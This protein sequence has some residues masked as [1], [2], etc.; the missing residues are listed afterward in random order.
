M[1]I[2]Y[3]QRIEQIPGVREVSI[4]Q[5][6][7][8]VYKEP[9]NMFARMAVEPER[10]FTVYPEY[11][12][13][14]DQKKAFVQERS[15]CIIG[16]EISTKYGINIGDKMTLVGDIFPVTMEFVV[17]GIYDYAPEPES[18][19]FHLQYLFESLSARRRDFAGMFII[20]ADS[21]DSANRIGPVV[22]DMFRNSPAHYLCT[23]PLSNRALRRSGGRRVVILDN[24]RVLGDDPLHDCLFSLALQLR[25]DIN[26]RRYFLR[27]RIV[28]IFV[29]GQDQ[30]MPDIVLRAIS[31]FSL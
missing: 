24:D 8:G 21:V 23:P 11:K 10:F 14:E 30:N 18:M 4:M 28:R 26:R 27:F 3:R 15:A 1:P 6:F 9:K 7:G 2:S 20:L 17:R 25:P 12:L 5:W 29:A 22:D 16:R 31:R 19:F 13:P